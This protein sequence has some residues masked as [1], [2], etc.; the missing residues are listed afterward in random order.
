MN[1]ARKHARLPRRASGLP[2]R[3]GLTILSMCAGVLVAL[4]LVFLIIS[5]MGVL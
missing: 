3:R 5:N 1:R 2:E 4:G